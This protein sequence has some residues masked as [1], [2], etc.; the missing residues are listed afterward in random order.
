MTDP[1]L[2][3]MAAAEKP[4]AAR[5]AAHSAATAGSI[6]VSADRLA[7]RAGAYDSAEPAA[8]AALR[9][10]STRVWHLGFI[11]QADR[12]PSSAPP[13]SGSLGRIH[14]GSSHVAATRQAPG[15]ESC[16]G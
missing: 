11:K 12:S 9:L 10:S 16:N 8:I 1:L 2:G 4:I 5:E 3:D 13:S 14:T 7:E 15:K 6:E